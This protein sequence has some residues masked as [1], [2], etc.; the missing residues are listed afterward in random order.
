MK[1]IDVLSKAIADEQKD[2]VGEL[3]RA[4]ISKLSD[5]D[6]DRIAKR[7]VEIMSS[8]TELDEPGT[9]TGTET[10]PEAETETETENEGGENIDGNN[11]ESREV[12]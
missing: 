5:G 6:V 10:E 11:G 2:E 8:K 4:N 3:G 7:M 1:N 12:D 9:E